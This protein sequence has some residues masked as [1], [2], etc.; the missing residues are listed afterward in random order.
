MEVTVNNKMIAVSFVVIDEGC[1]FFLA[2]RSRFGLV[3]WANLVSP[4]YFQE[5]VGDV[6]IDAQHFSSAVNLGLLR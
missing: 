5:F 6:M 1:V 4:G 2:S 3:H